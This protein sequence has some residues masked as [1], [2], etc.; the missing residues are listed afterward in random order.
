MRVRKNGAGFT[1]IE[2]M[3]SITV[4]AILSAIAAPSMLEFFDSKR[5][6]NQIEGIA[7]LL[8]L[9]KSESMRRSSGSSTGVVSVT[10]SPG[11]SWYVGLSNN[12]VGCSPQSACTINQAGN[13]VTKVWNN[14]DCTGCSMTAPA[15][16]QV[17]VFSL[18]GVVT[19]GTNQPITIQSPR[20]KQLRASIS[21]LGRI[22]V[23]S[24]SAS[25]SGYPSC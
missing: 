14:A 9:A 12:S 5:L 7:D 24:P 15:S 18:R 25:V 21:S 23:C 3:V 16:Q 13:S 1:L 8:Q 22:S 19:G 4:L 20:G 10:L 11:T 6:I 2:L 17:I